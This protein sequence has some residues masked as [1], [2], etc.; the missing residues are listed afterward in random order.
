M[1][2]DRCDGMRQMISSNLQK[3]FA[4]QQSLINVHTE[5][6][7]MQDTVAQFE[8]HMRDKQETFTNSILQQTEL[9]QNSQSSHNSTY[10]SVAKHEQITPSSVTTAP[11]PASTD[12]STGAASHSRNT[13]QSA[14]PVPKR[15]LQNTVTNRQT[16]KNYDCR[17]QQKTQKKRNSSLTIHVSAS[18]QTVLSNIY[19]KIKIQH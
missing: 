4:M 13:S 1:V 11:P 5:L 19:F 14:T 7:S 9:F 18:Y 15:S 2:S 6:C 12:T 10:A 8:R 16:P 3:V 17:W